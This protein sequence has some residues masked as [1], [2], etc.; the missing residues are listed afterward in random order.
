MALTLDKIGMKKGPPK[1]DWYFNSPA[2]PWNDGEQLQDQTE[3]K[4]SNLLNTK[5]QIRSHIEVN[6]KSIRSQI[7]SQLEVKPDLF[8]S[9]LGVNQ[10][11]FK[12]NIEV[13]Q[14]SIRSPSGSQLEVNQESNKTASGRDD[15]GVNWESIRS[16]SAIDGF[17]DKIHDLEAHPSE[18]FEEIKRL[19]SQQLT[20]FLFIVE[21]CA[22]RG[23]LSTGTITSSVLIQAL[24]TTI[25]TIKGQL[26]RLIAKNLIHREKGKTG[27]GGFYSLRITPLV[28]S[29]ATE[30]QRIAKRGELGVSWESIRS[31][32]EKAFSLQKAENWESNGS[33][34]GVHPAVKPSSSSSSELNLNKTTTNQPQNGLPPEWEDIDFSSLTEIGFN[35]A[36]ILQFLQRGKLNPEQ[37][38]DS[39]NAFSYDLRRN[40]KIKEIKT[41]PLRYLMKILGNGEIYIPPVNYLS[42]QEESLRLYVERKKKLQAARAA[43]EKAAADFAFEEW[44]Q[45]LSYERKRELLPSILKNSGKDFQDISLRNHFDQE[46]WPN[47]R[48]ELLALQQGS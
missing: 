4:E 3:L 36:H 48:V 28:R 18:P 43:T 16:Q 1:Q 47:K 10:E 9:Q 27:R 17:L 8:G 23:E 5:K 11:S 21:C 20:L 29:A 34:L 31:Q 6:Q 33:Q 41:T 44:I 22:A 40:Q 42:P 38:Q 26:N 2:R 37:V 25:K 46:V 13:N 12:A 24:Q 39:I 14:E 32:L 35:R 30:Y 15:I 7:S 19:S 45:E